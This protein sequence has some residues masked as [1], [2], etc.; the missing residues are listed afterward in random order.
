MTVLYKF[1]HGSYVSAT[2]MHDPEQ[3]LFQLFEGD[4]ISGFEIKIGNRI[5]DTSA[6]TI[7]NVN[8]TPLERHGLDLLGGMVPYGPEAT[9]MKQKSIHMRIRELGQKYLAGQ[10]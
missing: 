9:T 6:C 5:I 3:K 4:L 2:I 8:I 10:M 7:V 1:V